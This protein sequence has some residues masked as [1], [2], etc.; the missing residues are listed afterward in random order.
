MDQLLQWDEQ[1]FLYLNNL[2]KSFWDPMWLA[3]SG[4]KIW[5]PL[6]ALLIYLL[7]KK[8]SIKL[9]LITVG[10][11]VLNTFITD[12]GSV[13]LFKE[14]FQRLRPCHVEELLDKMRLVKA[15]CGGHYGFV[16][17]HASNTF[18]MAVLIGGILQ[19]YY[20]WI[21]WAL[22]FWAVL[23][24]YSRIYLGVHYPLDITFG[25]LYGCLSGFIV[26]SMFRKINK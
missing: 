1:L 8:L 5:I 4:V 17:S 16:S 21:R 20:G 6:Y 15:G 9:F 24:S 11:I 23:V 14:Q 19:S 10:L 12:Q 26:L 25:A 18:G 13:M 22:L 3:I 7:F 2:G